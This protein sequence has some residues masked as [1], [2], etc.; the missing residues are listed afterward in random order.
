MDFIGTM[1]SDFANLLFLWERN[2]H[3]IYNT[4]IH[5]HQEKKITSNQII[6]KK[7]CIKLYFPLSEDLSQNP[8][9]IKSRVSLVSS[10]VLSGTIERVAEGVG[11]GG[12]GRR[13]KG[14]FLDAVMAASKSRWYPGVN[15][16]GGVAKRIQDLPSC[17]RNQL[18]SGFFVLF[19]STS[20]S[21]SF[22]FTSS[23]TL[24]SI[25][26]FLIPRLRDHLYQPPLGSLLARFPPSGG[27]RIFSGCACDGWH[28][29]RSM[30]DQW[31]ARPW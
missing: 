22:S 30:P 15:P 13:V 25:P 1:L 20:S 11:G 31:E 19:S 21:F 4:F 16:P 12:W 28:P 9:G 29:D 6:D 3:L 26:L 27:D 7:R 8:R 2:W 23:V 14:G 5:C 17:A 10:R 24:I 18:L